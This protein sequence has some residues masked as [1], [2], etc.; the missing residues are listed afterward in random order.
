MNHSP[1]LMRAAFAAL[2]L[3][4]QLLIAPYAAALSSGDR[5]RCT[6]DSVNVRTSTST[7][8]SSNIIG[9]V[10][11][12]D[13]G[14]FQS[15]PTSSGGYQWYYV[16]W[17]KFSSAGYTATY[18]EAVSSPTPTISSISPSSVVG[19]ASQS[20][21][22]TIYG[23]NFTSQSVVHLGYRDNNYS[24]TA[25]SRTPTFN[26]STQLTI[27]INVGADADTWK[28]WVKNGTQYSNQR[29]FNVT[30]PDLPSPTLSSISP[31]S[32]VGSNS[33]R[34]F[35]LAGSNFVNGAAVQ[36]AYRDSN[37]AFR[38]TNSSPSFDSSSQLRVS[39]NTQTTVDTWRIRVRNPDGKISN[40]RT[41]EVTAPDLPS[42]T[43]NSISPSSVTGS[44]SSRTF[45]LT[46]SNFASGA[47]V[48]VAYRD[49]NY[50]F[51]DTNNAPTF[52]SPSQ[53]RVS[54]N[55][56][57]TADTWRVR[58]R[59]ADGK[60]SNERT[61]EVTS[62]DGPSPTLGS[63]SPSS[64]EGK[65]EDRSFTLRGNNFVAGAHVQAAFRSNGYQFQDTRNAPSV[66]SATQLTVVM[67]TQVAVDTWQVRVRNPDGKTSNAVYL[68]VTAGPTSP[69]PTPTPPITPTPPP[70][71]P[72]PPIPPVSPTPPPPTAPPTT[73]T[74]PVT[75]NLPVIT[76]ISRQ[77]GGVFLGGAGVTN[78]FDVNVAW[79]GEPGSVRFSVAGVPIATERGT[80][81]G[82]SHTFNMATDFR[83]SWAPI[84]MLVTAEN[85]AGE[86]SAPVLQ[87]VCVL[88]FPRWLSGESSEGRPLQYSFGG[89]DLKASFA[90]EFPK[91]HLAENGPINI[92]A[93]VPFIGGKFGLTETFA[94]LQG[95]ISSNSGRGSVTLS[96]QTG[97]TAAGQ[98]LTGRISGTGNLRL[99][100]QDGL[101]LDDTTFTLSLA[102]KISKEAGVVDV[103]PQ[104]AVWQTTPVI[105]NALKWFNKHATLTGDIAPSLNTTLNFRPDA[106][107]NLAFSAGE[108]VLGLDLRATL[109]ANVGGERL[110]A[111]GWVAGGG[112]SRVGVPANPF[113]R[114][115]K[116]TFQAG[117]EL[118]L[119]AIFKKQEWT[120]T[121]AYSCTWTPQT[122]T[123]C[124]RTPADRALTA[125]TTQRRGA[126]DGFA[127]IERKYA[128]YGEYARFVA[129]GSNQSVANS[130]TT[131][132]SN[133]FAAASP[134]TVELPGGAQLLLWA[135]AEPSLP[136]TQA[137]GIMWSVRDSAGFWSEPQMI[138]HDTNG[139][140]SPVVGVAA[141]GRAVAAWLR[142]RDNNFSAS[143]QT[144]EDIARF[145]RSFEVVTAS[146]DPAARSWSEVTALTDD[147]A[148]DTNVR[149][150]RDQSGG[151]LLTWLSNPTA[152]LMSSVESPS[153]L[154]Y[155]LHAGDWNTPGVVADALV[156]VSNH[157]A[158]L[159]NG[160]GF[161][162][163]PR[164][165]NPDAA[166]DG[167]LEVLRLYEGAWGAVELFA[168]GDVENR[169]PT[170]SYDSAGQRHVVWLRGQDL[171][172]ATLEDPSPRRIRAGSTGLGFYD[173]KL[174]ANADGNLALIYQQP[175][176]TGAA[177]FFA[178]IYFPKTGGWGEGRE[179]FQDPRLSRHPAAYFDAN[180]DLR[181]S[182]V[183]SDVVRGTRTVVI[184]GVEHNVENVPE[185]GE[186]DLE[187]R[188]LKGAS[189]TQSTLANISTRLRVGIDDNA[190]IGGVI[191]TG[192]EAKKVMIRAIGPSLP[193]GD[194]L[195]DPTL[196]LY[197]APG[198]LL[199]QNDNW[200]ES[201]NHQALVDTSIAPTAELES[202]IVRVLGPGAYTAVVQGV[203][204]STGI[205][206]VEAYDLE[207]SVGSKLANIA[208]RGLVGSGDDVLIA[209]TIIV[210]QA[211][212]R[213]VVRAIGPSLSQAG[214]PNALADPVLEL[215]DGNG[216][217]IAVNDNWRESQE[218]AVKATSIPPFDDA[219]SAIVVNLP[220]GAYTAVVAGKNDTTGV[221]LVE[222]YA[223]D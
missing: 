168:A 91:P 128:Q 87:N 150:S 40:E 66:D 190:L 203:D 11:Y 46:G 86:E 39:I 97:F 122:G 135:H 216:T 101:R 206:V 35:T 144:A 123:V 25:T 187:S 157:V 191:V 147:W 15:G 13:F 221:A 136:L 182:Y 165:P 9:Q 53:L 1:R 82:A 223:L 148:F 220:P 62:P 84:E 207:M 167:V 34:T 28:V 57:T 80:A 56:Q 4:F 155:S 55:T 208:T 200:Q 37:Y 126:G 193:F 99:E 65:N 76:S 48:Q 22:F 175:S 112:T 132:I 205:G 204:N 160:E 71:T 18:V 209:G 133:L 50:A 173:A 68:E 64:I 19:S 8:S 49:S 16:K 63:I 67:N 105:G 5:V 75:G 151:L 44:T 130:E 194:T 98:S 197:D 47:S 26:S 149:L 117:I 27:T 69:P 140:F 145:Y 183:A 217:S 60:I 134:A 43:L 210:G 45:T 107:G 79:N 103:I 36:V 54:I 70:P 142:S 174:V 172:A 179:L 196:A 108:G 184:D 211:P 201:A 213:V 59:S 38:D 171:V 170:V 77:H 141:D 143:V 125:A 127:V 164:D 74:P 222:V 93:F 192:T 88:P 158:A 104:L 61:F 110:T 111:T 212:Q 12:G 176:D 33:S 178:S 23:S 153:T 156:G 29:T 119:D 102:G 124:G 73:P 51:R 41:F 215:F 166:D 3:I 163:I 186:S 109:Q 85:A 218:G 113:V 90:L 10:N 159:R 58:V 72:T 24:Q 14:T 138:L 94:R 21:T 161:V 137:T 30:A 116:L 154:K 32:V 20:R 198:N 118:K 120:A 6:G 214:V 188:I 219:E 17:D 199:E 180:G 169:L 106:N 152:E 78:R 95:Q 31:A 115:V 202:A 162:V 96:G 92:P 83:P 52:D 181:I 195:A 121:T 89:G 42:P 146:F 177:S 7:S 100:C 114:E 139:E 131:V 185:E 129:R 81:A 189:V 2:C